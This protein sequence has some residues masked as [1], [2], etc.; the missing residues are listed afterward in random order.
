MHVSYRARSDQRLGG[1]LT[2][3]QAIVTLA[4][5]DVDERARTEFMLRF[6]RVFQRGGG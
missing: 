6:D 4:F 1:L 5:V 2:L 3:P